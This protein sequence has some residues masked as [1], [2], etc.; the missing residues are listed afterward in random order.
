MGGI[1]RKK[2]NTRNS[3][4][5]SRNLYT[6]TSISRSNIDKLRN[7]SVSSLPSSEGTLQKS[8]EHAPDYMI[9]VLV[10]LLIAIGAIIGFTNSPGLTEV[11]GL[12]SDFYTKK[13][14]IAIGVGLIAFY[15]TSRLDTKIWKKLVVPT[16]ISAALIAAAVRLFGTPI[17]G[18]YRWLDVGGV[19]IQA[20]EVIKFALVLWLSYFIYQH[21]KEGTLFEKDNIK[22]VG[23]VTAIVL[24]VVAGLQSDLGSA[25]VMVAMVFVALFIAGLPK[26]YILTSVIAIAIA[27]TLLIIPSAYRVQRVETFLNPTA[28]CQDAGYQVCQALIS[29]GSGGV[30]GK[31]LGRSVQA[32]G[33]LP[34]ALSDSIFALIA[35]NMGFIGA[36]FVVLIF[37]ELFRR[38]HKIA[39]ASPNTYH[40]YMV[41]I[42]LI[43]LASQT[44]IN[45]G[46]M[47]GIFP[48]KGITLPL[49]SFGGTSIIF[50][51]AALGICFKISRFTDL[52]AAQV[53]ESG[54]ELRQPYNKPQQNQTAGTSGR[55]FR[56]T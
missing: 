30:V 52:R 31:G 28:D 8:R 16:L 25:A 17:Y 12:P 36:A 13:Q 48:L 1:L 34:E 32:Y 15:I 3:V 2:R 35:E 11:R 51:L 43:W 6:K 14:F 56:R 24:V 44:A 42:I 18:A 20:A 19:S 4:I 49:I 41:Y 23:L 9:L 37:L 55:V 47:I 22:R 46:A 45:I 38:L 54:I 39:L 5:A 7:K 40:R 53:N 21:K 33:Y 27:G 50:V 26:K 10:L 29:V